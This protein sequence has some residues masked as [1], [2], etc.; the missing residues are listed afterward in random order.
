VARGGGPV[1]FPDGT[2]SEGG[3]NWFIGFNISRKFY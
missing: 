2:R 3:T 1:N